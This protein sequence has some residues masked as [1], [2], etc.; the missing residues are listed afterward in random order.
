ME[1]NHES[2]QYLCKQ[3]NYRKLRSIRRLICIT[4]ACL[5]SIWSRKEEKRLKNDL[6]QIYNRESKLQ[7]AADVANQMELQIAITAAW[8]TFV[9]TA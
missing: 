7:S 9:S 3:K 6:I 4:S 2:A 5:P 1:A 8:E